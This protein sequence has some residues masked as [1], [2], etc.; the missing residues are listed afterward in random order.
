[1]SP[2]GARS[3]GAGQQP[4]TP[5]PVRR[6]LAGVVRTARWHR[7]LLAA[8]LLAGAFA[9][10]LDTLAPPAPSTVPVV[11]AARDLPGGQPLATRDL[12]VA[13]LPAEAVPAGAIRSTHRLVGATL[14]SAVRAGEVVTDVR[15]VGRE[16]VRAL[17]GDLVATPVRIGDADVVN[18]L[19]AGDVVDVLAAGADPG[20]DARLVAANARVLVVPTRASDA[21]GDSLG[22][23]ALVVLATSPATAARLA[24]AAVTERLSVV[25]RGDA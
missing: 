11:T 3:S 2:A 12:T 24:G 15:V 13:R 1:M 22:E 20:E 9:L 19:S 7:R 25:L 6:W 8:G 4:A 21:F 17:P 10:A 23:G 18:L 14:V 5:E 16:S